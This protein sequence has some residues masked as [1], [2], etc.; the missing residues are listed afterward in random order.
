MA[1]SY[2]CFVLA[3]VGYT[4][5]GLV[6]IWNLIK[7]GYQPSRIPLWIA[8]VGVLCH[9][10]GMY[11]RWQEANHVPWAN[12]YESLLMLSYVIAV[13]FIIVEWYRPTKL[14]GIVVIPIVWF[15]QGYALNV[16]PINY[17]VRATNWT[18]RHV[19][20]RLI[21][22]VPETSVSNL[23]PALQS[24][25]IKIH[26]PTVFASYA[27]YTLAFGTGILYLVQSRKQKKG[28][29]NGSLSKFDDADTLDK[30]TYWLISIGTVLLGIGIILGAMWGR[31][32]WGS[33]WFWDPKETGAL[34][35]WLIY[36]VYLHARLI[37]GWRGSKTAW[38]AIIGFVA[39]MLCYYGVNVLLPQFVDAGL[40]SYGTPDPGS[41]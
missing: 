15:F 31:E 21:I 6:Y 4:L 29:T 32:A 13:E 36:I 38:F 27:A 24:Y 18:F 25:W 9:T 16:P 11:F 20:S 26:V 12:M 39:V 17:L 1:N 37:A 14:L 3:Y 30:Q 41:H 19:G 33:Y 7:P 5:A 10:T 23:M 22:P 34:I 2:L 35:T 40:H 8:L 28:L